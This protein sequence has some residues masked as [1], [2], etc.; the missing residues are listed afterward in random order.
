MTTT[1]STTSTT[2][3]T[4]TK[5][6]SRGAPAA[7]DMHQQTMAVVTVVFT[8]TEGNVRCLLF[9][10]YE[11]YRRRYRFPRLLGFKP[12]HDLVGAVIF[13]R[14]YHLS[15][16]RCAHTCDP[17]ICR[18]RYRISSLIVPTMNYANKH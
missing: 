8:C 13:S 3:T 1:T 9:A 14:R 2:A 12:G 16:V 17:I 11:C 4:A 10:L 6:I 5:L 7:A 18:I 15:R